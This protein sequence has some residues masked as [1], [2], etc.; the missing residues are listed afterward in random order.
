[1]LAAAAQCK[2]AQ[3][4][5]VFRRAKLMLALWAVRRF[6]HQTGWPRIRLAVEFEYFST[7]LPPAVH[8]TCGQAQDDNVQ[9]AADDQSD[10]PGAGD[11]CAGQYNE[12]KHAEYVWSG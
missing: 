12:I 4:R 9:K 5:N 8:Q 1:M 3:H 7:L 6:P 10:D 11:R 2:P